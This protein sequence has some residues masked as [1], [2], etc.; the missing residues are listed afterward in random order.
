MIVCKKHKR[1]PVQIYHQCIGCEL[2][3]YDREVGKLNEKVDALRVALHD[4]IRRP[5]GVIPTSAEPFYDHEDAIKAEERRVEMSD[6]AIK[7]EMK[8]SN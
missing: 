3:A 8:H 5:M 2:E 4:A 1:S 7:R 6:E